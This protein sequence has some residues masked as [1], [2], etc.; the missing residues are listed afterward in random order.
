M[1]AAGTKQTGLIL[2]ARRDAHVSPADRTAMLSEGFRRMGWPPY[3]AALEECTDLGKPVYAG[4]GIFFNL[5]DTKH[6]SAAVFADVPAGIDLE[7]PRQ[8]PDAMKRRLA[9]DERGWMASDHFEA[10]QIQRFLR[11][12]TAK[13][14]YGKMTGDGISPQIL[15]ASFASLMR[16]CIPLTFR[17]RTFRAAVR[18]AAQSLQA[19]GV[20]AQLQDAELTLTVCVSEAREFRIAFLSKSG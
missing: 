11:L 10:G 17:V 16:L 8:I 3:E 6:F 7:E 19:A 15:D 18:F 1:A 4:G 12:W 13:E 9:P 2:I 14:A 5:S 20:F